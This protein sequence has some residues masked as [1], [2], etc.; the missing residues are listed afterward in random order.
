MHTSVVLTVTLPHGRR[1]TGARENKREEG[2]RGRNSLLHF[3]LIK[4]GRMRL[5]VDGPVPVCVIINIWDSLHGGAL[6]TLLA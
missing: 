1:R 6:M 2:G 3:T 4:K 5:E